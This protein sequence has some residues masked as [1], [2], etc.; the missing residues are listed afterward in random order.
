LENV[1]LYSSGLGVVIPKS[2]LLEMN[3]TLN[4]IDNGSR[5]SRNG[6]LHEMQFNA[7]VIVKDQGADFIKFIANDMKGS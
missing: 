6:A 4:E 2:K 7:M 1:T 3:H 5:S